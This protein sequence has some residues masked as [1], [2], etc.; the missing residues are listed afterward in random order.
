MSKL[1]FKVFESL[2]PGQGRAKSNN[3]VPM[4][5]GCSYG[6]NDVDNNK[7]DF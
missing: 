6:C 7:A 2:F 1:V 3:K 5:R 4:E